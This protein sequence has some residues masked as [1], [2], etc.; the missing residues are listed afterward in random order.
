LLYLFFLVPFGLFLTPALQNFT[1]SFIDIG[2]RILGIPHFSTDMTIEISAGSFYVAEACAG[3][4]FLIASVAFGVFFGMLNYNSTG[5]RLG[6]I[7]ASIIVPIIANGFRAL[8]IVVLGNILGSAQAAAADHIIYG[9]LF[10][11]CV[12]LLLV[13]GGL[14]FR[15]PAIKAIADAH[16][17]GKSRYNPLPAV[18]VVAIAAVGPMTIMS[19]DST[20]SPARLE[21]RPS[22]I[23][24]PGC[25]LLPADQSPDPASMRATL[26]CGDLSW[27]ISVLALP[28][29]S[30]GITVARARADLI[31]EIDSEEAVTIAVPGA[32]GWQAIISHDPGLVIATATMLNGLP[33]NGGISGRISLAR[34]S[35]ATTPVEPIVMRI[36]MRSP[37]PLSESQTQNAIEQ[38]VRFIGAQPSLGNELARAG[39]VG[40]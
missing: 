30:T 16:P 38:L 34:N 29:R 22:L 3:L 32:D 11:S 39:H 1:A 2:L 21:V 28:A 33:L 23:A 15:E 20:V 10:F 25:T 37:H 40:M 26:S 24:P 7:V 5:R 18:A 4:R 36:G 12:T 31:G 13:L 8:G 14:P 19:I 27:S 9:W 35:L 6:F 17:A